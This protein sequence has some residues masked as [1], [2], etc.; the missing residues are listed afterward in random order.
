MLFSFANS[1][2]CSIHLFFGLMS[3]PCLNIST[4]PAISLIVFVIFLSCGVK[5]SCVDCLVNNTFWG[6]EMHFV[7]SKYHLFE[8]KQT[9]T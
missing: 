5:S 6:E 2:T 1:C 4:L 8:K 7:A 9:A 3:P